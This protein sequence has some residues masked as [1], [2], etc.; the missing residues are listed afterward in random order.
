ML[1]LANTAMI[2]CS[3]HP[4][5]VVFVSSMNRWHSSAMELNFTRNVSCLSL[6][7]SNLKDVTEKNENKE[8]NNASATRHSYASKFTFI[9]RLC[10][11][12]TKADEM[13]FAFY[14]SIDIANKNAFVPTTRQT[15]VVQVVAWNFVAQKSLPTLRSTTCFCVPHYSMCRYWAVST[16]CL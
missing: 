2:L 16:E 6:F 7:H 4:I 1:T 9:L 10:V 11:L 5:E 13:I 12:R 8:R 15:F 3:K 14:F